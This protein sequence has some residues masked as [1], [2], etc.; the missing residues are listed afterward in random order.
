MYPGSYSRQLL[1]LG[2]GLVGGFVPNTR[3]NIHPLVLGA[4]LAVLLVK[5]LFGDYD[6]GYQWTVSDIG[7]VVLIGGL[8]ALGALFAQRSLASK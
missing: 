5:I 2:A 1:A 6:S 8:G 4:I 3:S 7:F